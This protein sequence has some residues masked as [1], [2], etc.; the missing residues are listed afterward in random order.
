M[1]IDISKFFI[2]IDVSKPYFD[3]SLLTVKN[4]QKQ[5]IETM[6]FENTSPG[7]KLFEKWLKGHGV[8]MNGQSLVVIE[9]T[10]IYHRLIW[11]FCS[12]KNLPIHIGNAAHIKWSFGIARG[13]NDKIDSL[14]LCNY[15][16]K[17]ADALKATPA[18]DAELLQLKDFVS[19]RTKLLKQLSAIKTSVKELGSVNDKPHQKLIEKSLKAATDGIAKSIDSIEAQIRKIIA[20]NEAFRQSYD[21]LVSIPGIGHVTAVYLIG[22]TANFAGCPTGKELACYAGV[23]PFEHSSGISIKGKTRVHRMANKELKRLLHLCALSVIQH[24]LEFKNYYNR[25]QDEGKHNMSILNAI[26]NKIV[27]RVAAVIKSKSPYK[28]NYKLVA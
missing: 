17:E 10:G 21:L 22:C 14:R 24:N 20:N 4:Y 27:L 13:K 11:A 23:A 25:K 1:M 18:L 9:N 16:F 15:A 2:G 12:K 6:R 3:V 5:G 28:E 7:I 8:L 19:A 26:R